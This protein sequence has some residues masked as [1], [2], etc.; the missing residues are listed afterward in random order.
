MEF[1]LAFTALIAQAVAQWP[2]NCA[3]DEQLR[4]QAAMLPGS[5]AA[6][7]PC[8]PRCQVARPLSGR[9]ASKQPFGH[10]GQAS[11]QLCHHAS[12]A[13]RHRAP[14]VHRHPPPL[15][16]RSCHP[17]PCPHGTGAL[18]R[19]HRGL[20]LALNKFRFGT[21][22]PLCNN[23]D[24]MSKDGEEGLHEQRRSGDG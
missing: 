4:R 23:L 20:P 9:Q 15:R 12:H 21:A 18:P 13:A 14:L 19:T 17:P 16:L 5:Q 8:Q 2:R 7:L 11:K 24:K 10:A 22:M 6:R 3:G 1:R